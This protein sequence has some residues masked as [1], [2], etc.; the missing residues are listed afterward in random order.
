LFHLIFFPVENCNI[1]KQAIAL[2]GLGLSK[3]ENLISQL[4]GIKRK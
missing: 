1:K 3:K 4:N 2:P